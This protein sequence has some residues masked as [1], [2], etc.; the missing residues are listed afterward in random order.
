M[1]DSGQDS[2]LDLARNVLQTEADAILGLIRHVDATFDRALDVLHQCTGRVVVT[3]VG[4]SG[5]IGRKLAATL[6]S[7]GTAAVFLHA[8]EA[9][10]G[11]LGVVQAGDVVVALSHSGE[12]EELLR[13]IPAV[14]RIGAGLIAMTGHPAGTLG[15]AADVTLTC[16]VAEEACPMNLAPTAST[17]AMLAMSDALAMALSRRKG[18]REDQFATLHP[19][20]RIGKRLMRVDTVMHHGDAL[21]RVR[22]ETPMFELIQEISGKRLGMTCVVDEGGHL[23]GIVTDGDLRRHLTPDLLAR[24]AG[25]VMTPR[26]VTIGRA[27]LAIEALRLMEERKITSVVVVDEAGI[28][29]GVVHLHDLWPV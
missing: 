4:K 29:V 21:P 2:P 24:H 8:G 14:R 20:G 15:R 27:V 5:I 7:T 13:L 11:D 23:L 22:R 10:H 3:G 9:V 1:N 16:A 18:F 6:S 26:P 19:G 12:T 25:D 28:A 17:T